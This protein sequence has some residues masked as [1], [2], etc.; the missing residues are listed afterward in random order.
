M[1]NWKTLVRT[2]CDVLACIRSRRERIQDETSSQVGDMPCCGGKMRL[3]ANKRKQEASGKAISSRLNL[4]IVPR[5]S[6]ES[7]SKAGF[8]ENLSSANNPFNGENPEPP[9]ETP[10][11]D[12]VCPDLE[13]LPEGGEL[14]YP[15]PFPWPSDYDCEF[16]ECPCFLILYTEQY[17][18]G[19][20]SQC[21]VV[22]FKLNSNTIQAQGQ[23]TDENGNFQPI[24]NCGFALENCRPPDE[25]S[26]CDGCEECMADCQDLINAINGLSLTVQLMSDRLECLSQFIKAS[27]V[28]RDYT[29][30]HYQYQELALVR[31]AEQISQAIIAGMQAIAEEK[32][33]IYT[34]PDR[35]ISDTNT[36]FPL[37]CDLNPPPEP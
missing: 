23:A 15:T 29:A 6:G 22:F 28:E 33:P 36:N 35:V 21:R 25:T 8:S 20:S 9:P 4:P 5:Q 27:A 3:E 30:R 10:W 16:N 2:L 11:Y 32:I 17:C 31:G 18:L 12:I 37:V 26:C 13:A 24:Y 7:D 19:S 34:T 14:I 1:Q